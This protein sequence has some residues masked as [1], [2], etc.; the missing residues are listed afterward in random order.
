[1]DYKGYPGKTGT[2]EAV[3]NQDPVYSNGTEPAA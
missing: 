1:M 3:G 2:K